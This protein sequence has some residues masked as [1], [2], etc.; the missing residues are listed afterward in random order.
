MRLEMNNLCDFNKMLFVKKRLLIVTHKL[1]LVLQIS[2]FME[3]T[4]KNSNMKLII[5]NLTSKKF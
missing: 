1:L 3:R 4:I 2:P 5:R